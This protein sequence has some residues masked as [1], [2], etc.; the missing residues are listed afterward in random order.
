MEWTYWIT[1]ALV[2]ALF[3][4]LKFDIAR[5][6]SRIGDM[7]DRL[8]DVEKSVSSITKLDDRL[9]AVENAVSEIRGALFHRVR[10]SD[11]PS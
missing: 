2:V 9:R 8:R 11:S 1:P 10:P 3:G 4:W 5:L 7:D 6:E